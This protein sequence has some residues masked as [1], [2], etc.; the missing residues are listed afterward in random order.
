M[1]RADSG[2]LSKTPVIG[3]SLV[4]DLRKFRTLARN[5]EALGDTD[6]FY[7]VLSDPSKQGGQWN[8]DEFFA[9]GRAH[10]DTLLRT[11]RSA[12]ATFLPGRCLD[13]GCGVG[14]VTVP[15]SE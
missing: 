2:V 3:S 11:L 8:V 1:P 4:S 14:R 7:G 5:W 13:F 15:L 10:V 9:S 12:R 6:P